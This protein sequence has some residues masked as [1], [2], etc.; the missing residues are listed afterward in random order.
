MERL[1]QTTK[2]LEFGVSTPESVDLVDKGCPLDRVVLD[3]LFREMPP[4]IRMSEL[5]WACVRGEVIE[6]DD[7]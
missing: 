2:R 5:A 4:E 7:C 6:L 3:K 1:R